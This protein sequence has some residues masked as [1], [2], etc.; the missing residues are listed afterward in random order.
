MTTGS[1]QGKAGGSVD[2]VINPALLQERP[3]CLQTSGPEGA[4]RRGAVRR[5]AARCGAARCGAL[6]GTLQHN[7]PSLIL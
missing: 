7:E 1:G 3:Y 6:P 4:A 5:G 2:D